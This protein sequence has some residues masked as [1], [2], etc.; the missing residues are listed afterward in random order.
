V[1]EE[2]YGVPLKMAYSEIL[3]KFAKTW[4]GQNTLA[5]FATALVINMK[6]FIGFSLGVNIIITTSSLMLWKN[7]LECL[8]LVSY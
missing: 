2:P 1:R 5:Y 3:D 8:T 6:S 4:H 7:K